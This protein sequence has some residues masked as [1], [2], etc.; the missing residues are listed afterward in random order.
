[1]N[2]FCHPG[3]LADARFCMLMGIERGLRPSFGF[4]PKLMLANGAGAKLT[5]VDTK[6]S[7]LGVSGG[8]VTNTAGNLEVV[9]PPN[10]LTAGQV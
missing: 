4:K 10:A 2:I 8:S 5:P 7:A 1:M 9:F 6:V 3:I